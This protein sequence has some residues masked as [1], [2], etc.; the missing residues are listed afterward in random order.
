M[1][2]SIIVPVHNTELYLRKCLDTLQK[3]T[4]KN[5]EIIVIDDG[6]TDNSPAICDEYLNDSRFRIFHNV[7]NG[8]SDARNCGIN[9]A[10]GKYLMFV[11]SDDWLDYN[12][13][14]KLYYA[15]EDSKADLII[16]GNYNESTSETTQRHLFESNH[17]FSGVDFINNISIRTL[18]LTDAALRDPSKLDKLTPVW[19]RLY[20]TNII[21]EYNIAFKDL[22]TLPSECLQ[23]N[24]EYTIHANSAYYVNE[25]LY[26]YRRNTTHSVTKPYRNNLF[27]KWLWWISYEKTFL[28]KNNIF[29]Q[30]KWAFYSRICCSII[31]LGGNAL[32]LKKITSIIQETRLFLTDSAYKEA[33]E[34][35]DYSRCPIYWKIFFCSAKKK[36]I[37]IFVVL[38]KIM[39]IIL[40]KRKK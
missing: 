26:H 38:S 22:T 25:V 34:N 3:Q 32:K 30:Y 28:E 10:S 27:E 2:I 21:K 16:C 39:R 13:C 17:F 4:L 15:A 24:H 6:S 7:N 37:F 29:E 14:E 31:P 33:F 11:D 35:F 5:I 9:N 8:V 40:N 19:A 1:D 36:C 23:F 12:T 18:G 20:K